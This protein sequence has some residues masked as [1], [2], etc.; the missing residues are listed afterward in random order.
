[1][2]AAIITKIYKAT[3]EQNKEIVIWGNGTAR[4]EVLFAEDLADFILFSLQNFSSSP[5]IINVGSGVDNTINQYYQT[6][7]K[8]LGYTGT[9]SHDL[10]KPVGIQQKLLDISKLKA[11]GWR[12]KTNLETGVQKAYKFYVDKVAQ[13]QLTE[14]LA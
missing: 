9:F 12:P 4:R 10:S 8:T 3:I 1:V 14:D 5:N 11:L 6:I 2:V 13:S 7:A